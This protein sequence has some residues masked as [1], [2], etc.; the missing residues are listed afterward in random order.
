[1][2]IRCISYKLFWLSYS[3]AVHT[4]EWKISWGERE[5]KRH[6]K[7]RSSTTKWRES[8]S[9]SPSQLCW[10]WMAYIILKSG[11]YTNFKHMV[12]VQL[13]EHPL[14]LLVMPKVHCRLFTKNQFLR[15]NSFSRY[16]P[17]TIISEIC[18]PTR[19]W[20]IRLY[21]CPCHARKELTLSEVW[22][23]RATLV[24]S[25]LVQLCIAVSII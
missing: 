7:T 21:K 16:K 13:W 8:G 6:E 22:A 12:E 9:S 15:Y 19:R 18:K 3:E 11:Y 5:L 25:W 4:K 2:N 20:K 14:I 24:S 10:T 23:G 17:F 1:M